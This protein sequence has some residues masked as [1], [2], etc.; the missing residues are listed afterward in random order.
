MTRYRRLLGISFAISFPVLW[1]AIISTPAAENI[2]KTKKCWVQT[3]SLYHDVNDPELCTTFEQVLNAICEPPEKLQCNWTLPQ[4]TKG[5][6]KIN[7]QLIDY[8]K[9][10]SLVKDLRLSGWAKQ[11]REDNWKSI[12]PEVRKTFERGYISLE[13]ANVDIDRDGKEEYI[14]RSTYAP[15]CSTM[16]TIG[17]VN[18]QTDTLDENYDNMKPGF[19]TGYEIIL[20]KGRPYIFNVSWLSGDENVNISEV[21]R[22]SNYSICMFKYM[23]G[24]QLNPSHVSTVRNEYIKKLDRLFKKKQRKFVSINTTITG[25]MNNDGKDDVVFIF[26]GENATYEWITHLAVFT[27]KNGKLRFTDAINLELSNVKL[28]SITNGK[29][30]LQGLEYAKDDLK[31][32]PTSPYNKSFALIDNKLKEHTPLSLPLTTTPAMSIEQ[33]LFQAVENGDINQIR[34]LVSEGANVNATI[35]T[36]T[37]LFVAVRTNRLASVKLLL[38][39][40]ADPKLGAPLYLAVRKD[41]EIVRALINAGADVN[42]ETKPYKYTPLGN[43]AYN[44]DVELEKRKKE[45]GY[46]ESPKS[47]ETVRLLVSAGAHINHIDSF[48]E[49]PL[50]TAVRLNNVPMVRLLLELGADVHQYRDD[51]DSRGAQQGNSILMEAIYWYSVFKNTEPIKLLLKHG[52]NPNDKNTLVYD[53]ECDETTGGKCTWD[54]Y[55]ALTYAAKEGYLEVVE[56]LLEH[57]ADPFLPRQDGKSP[58]ELAQKNKH[59]KTAKLIEKYMAAKGVS[60]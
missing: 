13:V 48:S 2:S 34:F 55:T 26:Y 10:W 8:R 20:Y 24:K 17:V 25:D 41:T 42:V 22:G 54:G 18:R 50:R 60:K 52:A 14:V 1:L 43:A 49:S 56:L 46:E 36:L 16:G 45:L 4:E 35:G 53:E 38:E 32:S 3:K 33:L 9:Y 6:T 29:V 59:L 47:L 57:G 28:A 40:G 12:E 30:L 31:Y 37:P 58:Y 51:S 39:L 11:Y 44:S 27:Q 15:N 21:I 23:M 7:W 19:A 5:F